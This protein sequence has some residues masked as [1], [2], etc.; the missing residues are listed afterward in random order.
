LTIAKGWILCKDE[1]WVSRQNKIPTKYASTSPTTE[2]FGT[3]GLGSDNFISLNLHSVVYGD[4]Q[5]VILI[6]KYK[7]GWYEYPTIY[8]EWHS[9]ISTEYYFFYKSEFDKLRLI[10]PMNEPNKPAPLPPFE[11]GRRIGRIEGVIA[12][13]R[14]FMEQLSRENKELI[15]R[16]STL[17]EEK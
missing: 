6:K 1:Q 8:E 3:S 13:Q 11:R 10:I 5:Y 2:N 16:L 9:C 7:N 12:Y 14:H 4:K 15:S 17:K